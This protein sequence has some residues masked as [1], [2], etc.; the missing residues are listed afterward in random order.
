MKKF[1]TYGLHPTLWR[2]IRLNH[3]GLME[4]GLFSKDNHYLGIGII[5]R[6]SSLINIE[7]NIIFKNIDFKRLIK[8]TKGLNMSKHIKGNKIMIC[9]NTF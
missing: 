7:K 8:D 6:Y 2:K 1:I 5:S 3:S 4:V 9:N